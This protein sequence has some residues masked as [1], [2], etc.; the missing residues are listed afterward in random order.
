MEFLRAMQMSFLL[1]VVWITIGHQWK[2]MERKLGHPIFS[3][4]GCSF[5]AMLEGA[6]Q[7]DKEYELW[8]PTPLAEPVVAALGSEGKHEL[9]EARKKANK[10]AVRVYN[11][12]RKI[13]ANNDGT[14]SKK[15][16][17]RALKNKILSE[18]DRKFLRI[19]HPDSSAP[20]RKSSHDGESLLDSG[21]AWM[22]AVD[23]DENALISF[24]ELLDFVCLNEEKDNSFLG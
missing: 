3:L 6:Q 16:F 14:V 23:G 17:K 5:Q 9:S 2:A 20:A 8:P 15:E 12:I 21:A 18:D 13:D 11:I 22:L 7:L 1:E 19:P 24:E 10:T 4:K